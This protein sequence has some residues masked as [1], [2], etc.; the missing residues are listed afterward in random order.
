MYAFQSRNGNSWIFPGHA[1]EYALGKICGVPMPE[2]LKENDK[3]PTA[4]ITPTQKR[5]MEHDADISRETFCL[6]KLFLK[7]I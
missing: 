2:G 4:I 7:D 5:I 1:V 3:F 6:K